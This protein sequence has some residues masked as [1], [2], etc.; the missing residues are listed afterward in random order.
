MA[1]I[2]KTL[3]P[4]IRPQLN[5]FDLNVFDSLWI[6]LTLPDKTQA[7]LNVAYCPNKKYTDSFLEQLALNI[8]T[9][10]T[11]N[12]K[13]LMVGDYNINY[14]NHTEKV[15]LDTIL[16]PY[17]LKVLNNDPTRTNS[18]QSTQIDFVISEPEN[19]INVLTGD[20]PIKSDHFCNLGLLKAKYEKKIIGVLQIYLR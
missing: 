13:I 17:G 20:C 1:L 8:D 15:K 9:A 19:F 10:V 12:K 6:N 11:E 14:L 7:L 18:S 3:S 2:P 16:I 4:K 5:R